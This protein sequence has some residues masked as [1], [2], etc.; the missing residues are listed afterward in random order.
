VRITHAV[1][2]IL[3]PLPVF[4][5]VSNVRMIIPVA[6]HVL[7]EQSYNIHQESKHVFGV[8]TVN[9]VRKETQEVILSNIIVLL[10]PKMGLNVLLVSLNIN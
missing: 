4:Q 5:I 3:T 10:A 8:V 6:H 1:Q 7:R 9:V 2:E